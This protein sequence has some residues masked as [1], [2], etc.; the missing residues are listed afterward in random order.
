MAQQHNKL[1]H[2]FWADRKEK[3]SI[4][5]A[6]ITT[7]W[8]VLLGGLLVLLAALLVSSWLLFRGITTTTSLDATVD[9]TLRT[10]V[11]EAQLNRVVERFGTRAEQFKQL[12]NGFL[13]SEVGNVPFDDTQ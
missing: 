1:T 13:F 8:F 5:G 4:S 3:L 6:S 2:R 10:N 7:D 9:A 12:S 11:N